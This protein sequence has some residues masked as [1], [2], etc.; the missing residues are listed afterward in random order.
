MSIPPYVKD[1]LTAWSGTQFGSVTKSDSNYL[2]FVPRGVYVG[3]SGDLA[4]EDSGGNQVT[5]VGLAAG[6]VHPISPYK[7][8]STGTTATG[9]VIVA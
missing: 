6:V 4:V 3:G 8:L 1:Q 9:I 5:F 2:D 7:I